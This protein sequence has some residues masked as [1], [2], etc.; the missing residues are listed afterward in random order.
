MTE[1]IVLTK[2]EVEAE[3]HLRKVGKIGE[4]DISLDKLLKIW[5]G[6]KINYPLGLKRTTTFKGK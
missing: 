6:Y 2:R 4:W 3:I 1:N 5:M